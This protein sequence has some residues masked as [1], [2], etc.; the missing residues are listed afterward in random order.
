[1]NNTFPCPC[2][3]TACPQNVGTNIPD[4]SLTIEKAIVLEYNRIL[5]DRTYQDAWAFFAPNIVVNVPYFDIQFIGAGV[6][7]AYLYLGDPDISDQY[8]ILSS[9]V[10]L[11]LQ[12]GLTV[13]ARINITYQNLHTEVIWTTTNMWLFVFAENHTVIE[14]DIYI[15]S[16]GTYDVLYATGTL[17][18]DT[19]TLCESIMTDCV[20]ANLQYG[21]D[22]PTCVAFMD[23]VPTEIFGQ[24]ANGYSVACRSWHEVLARSD[25][26]VHCEHTGPLKLNP[27]DTPCNNF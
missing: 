5:V 2:Y 22:V 8:N 7:V 27:I 10:D 14:E 24:V 19:P 16:L 26:N 1:M 17:N 9:E 21:G 15:D 18:L 20:G 13:F 12:Q 3:A 23:T 4:E 11:M 25:P 6:N